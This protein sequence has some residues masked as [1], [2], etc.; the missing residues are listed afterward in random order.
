MKIYTNC[1]LFAFSL[2]GIIASAQADYAPA[3][4][5]YRQTFKGGSVWVQGVYNY[6][7]QDKTKNNDS[8]KGNTQGVVAGFDAKLSEMMTVGLGYGYTDTSVDMNYRDIDV[9]GHHAFL[10]G[11]YQPS[12]WF[13]NW[14]M[15]YSYD[16][17]KT[18]DE[19]IHQKSAYHTYSYTAHLINGYQF[20]SGFAPEVGVRYLGINR[21]PYKSGG[22]YIKSDKNDLLTG[23]VGLRYEKKLKTE[24]VTWTPR[25]NVH[26]VYDFIS[27]RSETNVNAI[28]VASYQV[29]GRRLHRFGVES[30]AGITASI[31]SFDVSADY[32]GGYRENFQSHT[33]MLRLKYNF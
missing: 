30:A 4:D 19:G 16:K 13:A 31:G 24:K 29:R 23:E 22:E 17:Y 7:K 12:E 3:S 20:E 26:L 10:Y 2:I 15:G 5:A 28:D 32:Q 8:F 14:M 6:A 21:R 27:D 11:K 33:G 1:F 18:K 9:K 25:V